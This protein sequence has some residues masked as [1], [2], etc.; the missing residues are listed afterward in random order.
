MFH[1]HFDIYNTSLWQSWKKESQQ[2]EEYNEPICLQNHAQNRP[3]NYNKEE[4]NT[5]WNCSLC[6]QKKN[7]TGEKTRSNS[8]RQCYMPICPLVSG[9]LCVGLRCRER[10]VNK[11]NLEVL[12]FHEE[13]HS[14]LRSNGQSHPWEEEYLIKSTKR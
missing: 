1:Q 7:K 13:L 9:F 3:S 10:R 4:A 5:E 8:W 6:N 11:L 12:T 14:G 2:P